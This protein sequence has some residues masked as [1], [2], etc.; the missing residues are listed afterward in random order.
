[1]ASDFRVPD[2]V[3]DLDPLPSYLHG[4]SQSRCSPPVQTRVQELPYGELDWDDFE[5]LCLRLARLEADVVHCQL[6]GTPGQK[7]HG[8]DLYA[9]T[10]TSQKYRVYQCK[11]QEDFDASKIRTAVQK[12]LSGKWVSRTETLVLCT[13]EPLVETKRAEALEAQRVALRTHG[14]SLE[15]W[16]SEQ[17]DRKL[18]DHPRLVDDFFGRGWVDAF[19]GTEVA[20]S[21]GGR[22]DARDVAEFRRQL[23]VFYARVFD[24]HDPGLPVPASITSHSLPL[25]DRYVVP[26]VLE[27][28]AGVSQT[29]PVEHGREPGTGRPADDAKPPPAEEMAYEERKAVDEWLAS[30]HNLL[31]LSGPGG[32][33]SS[34]LRFVALDLLGGSPRLGPVVRSWGSHLPVWVSFPQWTRMVEAEGQLPCSLKR[35]LQLWL[36]SW[37]E[38]RLWPLVDRAVDDDRLLLLVDGLDEWSS[39][40][41]AQVALDR[42]RVF[43]EQRNIPCVAVS[44]PHGFQRLG[45]RPAGWKIARLAGLSLDQQRQLASNWFRFREATRTDPHGLQDGEVDRRAAHRGRRPDGRTRKVPGVGHAGPDTPIALPA[46]LPS[47]APRPPAAD[48]FQGI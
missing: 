32:G 12:F 37:D 26:D 38:E 23:G 35:L 17:L 3:E 28:R 34:L 45:V 19:L 8:I 7:Q 20:R 18:K 13:K 2:S 24:K 1:M 5:R 6:Y 41:A 43:V 27:H 25:R 48:P 10:R 46:D 36:R 15:A 14:I 47:D 22:L 31:L 21:L 39:E 29:A 42:L 4:P 33:K 9:V 40:A 30:G 44:R 11:R 16:D